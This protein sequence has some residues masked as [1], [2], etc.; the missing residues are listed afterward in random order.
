MSQN[1]HP[2]LHS[3]IET[4]DLGP[5]SDQSLEN[6]PKIL[7]NLVKSGLIWMV[8]T[9]LEMAAESG[10]NRPIKLIN[11]PLFDLAL[12]NNRS[13]WGSGCVGYSFLE[14]HQSLTR[15]SPESHQS[16]TRVSPDSHHSLTRLSPDSHQTIRI[17]SDLLR[18]VSSAHPFFHSSFIFSDLRLGICYLHL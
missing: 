13:V 1:F 6:D 4:I 18:F 8:F 12:L 5:P 17:C 15:V 9:F 10:S 14:S 11:S 7:H 16:L 3:W 2:S